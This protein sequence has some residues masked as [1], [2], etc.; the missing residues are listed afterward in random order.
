MDVFTENETAGEFKNIQ[1][2]VSQPTL[3]QDMEVHAIT[4]QIEI[5]AEETAQLPA[6]GA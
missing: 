2:E 6:S 5:G 3:S 1:Y 4:A